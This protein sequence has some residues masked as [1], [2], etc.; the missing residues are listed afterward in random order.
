MGVI[1]E[2]GDMQVIPYK[3]IESGYIKFN[4]SWRVLVD[5]SSSGR[6]KL[7]D[8][9]SERQDCKGAVGYLVVNGPRRRNSR[10]LGYAKWWSME[11]LYLLPRV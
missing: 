1:L 10:I 5:V 11:R 6:Y 8:D 7:C 3:A 2:V 4:C 9:D